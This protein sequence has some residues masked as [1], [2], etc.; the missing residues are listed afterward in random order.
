MDGIVS[1]YGHSFGS[2]VR[3]ANR[4]SHWQQFSIASKHVKFSPNVHFQ[5]GA[6]GIFMEAGEDTRYTGPLG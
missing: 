1:I 5:H 2:Q 6:L 4:V 3:E